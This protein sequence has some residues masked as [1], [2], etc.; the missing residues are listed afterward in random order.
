MLRSHEITSC[1]WL[2]H[3]FPMVFLWFC[4]GFLGGPHSMGSPHGLSSF[5]RVRWLGSELLAT[6]GDCLR[7]PLGEAVDSKSSN[8]STE[9]LIINSNES[10]GLMNGGYE[11]IVDIWG[12][13]DP[14]NI[15]GWWFGTWILFSHDYW[16]SHHPNWRTRI[17]QRG[18]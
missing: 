6:S 9:L 12:F 16:E 4:H 13:F 18:G 5:P 7:V 10:V 2:N 15:T 3:H 8:Q 1:S 17:F 11:S 14:T